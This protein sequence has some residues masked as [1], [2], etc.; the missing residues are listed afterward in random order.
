MAGIYSDCSTREI[1]IAQNGVLGVTVI[2]GGSYWAVYCLAPVDS[3]KGD[4]FVSCPL[5][6]ILSPVLNI[7][8]SQ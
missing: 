2:G 7:S 4:T 6:P 3:G 5:S 1:Y 8:R